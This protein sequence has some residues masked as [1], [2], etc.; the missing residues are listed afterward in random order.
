MSGLACDQHNGSQTWISPPACLASANVALL[1]LLQ[2]RCPP[3]STGS[4]RLPSQL[5]AESTSPHPP[6]ASCRAASRRA[7]ALLRPGLV[8]LAPT[9][10]P[11]PANPW[12]LER[13]PQKLVISSPHVQLRE[14]WTPQG[15]SRASA[16][17]QPGLLLTASTRTLWGQAPGPKKKTHTSSPQGHLREAWTP[18]LPAQQTPAWTPMPPGGACLGLCLSR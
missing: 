3:V 10:A 5:P 8:P 11:A 7:P 16:L 13:H 6:H 12:H 14:A 17:R 18:A 4:L 1:L 2:A 9:T 15:S